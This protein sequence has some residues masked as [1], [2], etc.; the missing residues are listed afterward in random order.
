MAAIKVDGM[1]EKY[2][3]LRTRREELKKEFTSEDGKLKDMQAKI[4]DWFRVKM[5][6]D[7]VQNFKTNH[8]TAYK[9]Y[10]E[11]FKVA[12]WETFY[13]FV[14]DNEAFDLLK[15]DVN[16]T[17]CK[18]RMNPDRKG[19]YADPPPPGVNMTRIEKVNIKRG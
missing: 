7:G 15:H 16:K 5:D 2:V 8:G 11:S 14:Q 10:V 3:E 1:V 12:D 6:T 9:T 17:A 19:V 13:K 4:E 18:E